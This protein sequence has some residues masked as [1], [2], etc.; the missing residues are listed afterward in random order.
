VLFA[1]EFAGFRIQ[2][3]F[4]FSTELALLASRDQRYSAAL[5]L[6]FSPCH[7]FFKI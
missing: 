3:G 5:G 7:K 6:L 2:T 4:S 1:S